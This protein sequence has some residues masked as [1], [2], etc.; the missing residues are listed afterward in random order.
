[1]GRT[2]SVRRRRRGRSRGGLAE[3]RGAEKWVIVGRT[4]K[5]NV[6]LIAF[7]GTVKQDACPTLVGCL[8][9]M[10]VPDVGGRLRGRRGLGGGGG[11]GEEVGAWRFWDWALWLRRE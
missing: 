8:A 5:E 6:L 3:K 11:E 1:V 9:A 7:A 4:G 2:G 10:G